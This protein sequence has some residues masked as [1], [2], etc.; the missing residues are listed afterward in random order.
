METETTTAVVEVQPAKEH[1]YEPVTDGDVLKIIR[2]E[3]IEVGAMLI[4][5]LKVADRNTLRNIRHAISETEGHLSALRTVESAL[6]VK[7]PEPT[8]EEASPVKRKYVRKTKRT[9]RRRQANS[10]PDV[11]AEL[12]KI[13]EEFDAN[14]SV[15]RMAKTPAQRAK[16]RPQ[17]PKITPSALQESNRQKAYD[18][19]MKI[20]KFLLEG[21]E[22][23][24]AIATAL[25]I[26]MGSITM[27]L[28]HE[29]FTRSDQGVHLTPAGRQAASPD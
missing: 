27:V 15:N 26:P 10:S 23:P 9:Y 20:A 22:S 1:K 18:R 17:D 6:A 25:G 11:E 24:T 3:N 28:T 8:K 29:W 14:K 19:R 5:L 7:Y 13:D 12:K 2:E 16:S 21:P 4:H